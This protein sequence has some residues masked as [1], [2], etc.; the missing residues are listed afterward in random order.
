MKPT[1]ATFTGLPV[2]IFETMSQMA[3]DHGAINLGQGF[4][5]DEGPE[6]I[7]R[8]A[9]DALMTGPNQYPSMWGL[10]ELRQAL[11]RHQKRFYGLELDWQTE[12]LVTSGATEALADCML[13][14]IEPGDEVVLIEPLYDCY[15][16]MIRRVGGI[17]KFVR[18]EAP[19]WS[20]NE[21]DLAA[22]FSEKTKAIVLNNPMNP[23]A[24]VFSDEEL[25]L[26]ARYVVAYDAYAICDE[27]Y[28]HITFDGRK[29]RPF[30]TLPGMKERA[31]RVGSAGKTFS[32]TGW[33][34]GYI[35]GPAH[36]MAPISK[37]HQ[38]TTFTTAPNL[39]K[40]VAYGLDLDDAYFAGLASDLQHKR[41]HLTRALSQIGLTCA[42]S[43]GT[44][45][46]IADASPLQRFGGTDV[47]ICMA[48]TREA[49]V[50][51]VPVSPFYANPKEGAPF[52]RFCFSKADHVLDEAARRLA[53]FM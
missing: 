2:T 3:R 51:A 33:K 52:I 9:A 23:A 32:L 46:L 26:L 45:F 38:F 43:A 31:V 17:P 48:L 14:L 39:Q 30:M 5:D 4:P 34:I 20:L 24:K 19:D 8:V 40:A 53:A 41:D 35:S 25:A 49:G 10:P 21:S 7:R 13:A 6:D 29:H 27:V 22:A 28:E 12:I 37:A 15:E 50:T 36:L 18:L 1:N 44:Y 47:E 16:P 42:P 11:A